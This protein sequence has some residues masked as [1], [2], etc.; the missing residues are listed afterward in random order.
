MKFKFEQ[1]NQQTTKGQTNMKKT[2]LTAIAVFS[3]MLQNVPAAVT[4]TG[5]AINSGA[6]NL[7]NLTTGQLGVYIVKDQSSTNW[8]T[9]FGAGKINFDLSVAADATYDAS[10]FTVMS[11]K[12]VT[13]S[14]TKVVTS[15]GANISLVNGI[16]TGDEFAFLLFNT[17]TTTTVAGD[18]FSIYRAS[19][20]LIPS[21][22]SSIGF[23]TAP[24]SA[25]YQTL[26]A[27]SYLIGTGTVLGIAA[28]PE[29]SSAS[30]LALGVAGLVA[31]RVRRKS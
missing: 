9:L 18:T 25:S 7:L 6:S 5:T 1:K 31:L 22:G 12:S 3:F 13:G 2:I 19:D 17:S 29:P 11:S 16:S 28:I 10:L 24:T 23:S 30:L 20:W 14:S 26:N 21:D 8:N 4:F 15:P 27:S